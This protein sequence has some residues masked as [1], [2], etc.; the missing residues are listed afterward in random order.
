MFFDQLTFMIDDAYLVVMLAIIL[1]FLIIVA[2]AS[3]TIISDQTFK[4]SVR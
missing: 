4:N 2:F 1:I 3:T